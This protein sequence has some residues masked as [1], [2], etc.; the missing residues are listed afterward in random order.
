MNPLPLTIARNRRTGFPLGVRRRIATLKAVCDE[1]EVLKLVKLT[2]ARRL[3]EAWRKYANSHQ[4]VL[5]LVLEDK[6]ED[7]KVALHRDG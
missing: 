4:V 6:V 2:T 1:P 5:G 7:E 3:V